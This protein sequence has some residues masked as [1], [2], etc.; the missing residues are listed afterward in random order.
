MALMCN[1]ANTRSVCTL[2]PGVT[3]EQL[4]YCRDVAAALNDENDCNV[5]F[6]KDVVDKIDHIFRIDPDTQRAGEA[7]FVTIQAKKK[8]PNKGTKLSIK[9]P[10]AGKKSDFDIPV[11]TPDKVGVASAGSTIPTLEQIFENTCLTTPPG[12]KA[13]GKKPKISASAKKAMQAS[14]ASKAAEKGKTVA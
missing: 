14:K 5:A 3:V 2:V 1:G 9:S 10:E 8:S 6:R 4:Q 12:T 11:T 7:A 13:K